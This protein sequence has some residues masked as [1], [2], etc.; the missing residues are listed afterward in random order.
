MA[1]ASQNDLNIHGLSIQGV[2]KDYVNPLLS[3]ILFNRLSKKQK[4]LLISICLL[5]YDGKIVNKDLDNCLSQYNRYEWRNITFD[6]VLRTDI[7]NNIDCLNIINKISKKH[8]NKLMKKADQ[9][10]P[11]PVLRFIKAFKYFV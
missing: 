4:I 10:I 7:L 5:K 8:F 9:M 3:A 2:L 1:K 11:L 6:D